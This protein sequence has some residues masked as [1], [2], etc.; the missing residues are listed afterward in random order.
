MSVTTTRSREDGGPGL[1]LGLL[2]GGATRSWREP[3]SRADEVVRLSLYADLTAKAE[4]AKLHTVFE[5]DGLTTDPADPQP[6]LEPVTLL[7]ALSARTD[8]I[9]L[10]GSVSTSFTEPYNLAR[11]IASLDHISGGRA[12]WNIVTSAWGEQNFGKPLPPHDE[13]YAVAEEFTSLVE[14]LWASWDPDAIV[15]DVD[16]N[17]FVDPAKVHSV[18]WV[19][20]HFSVRGPLD[21]PATPQGRPILAQAGSSTAGK[22]FG[23]RHADVVFTTGLIDL[24]ESQ[25][26]Y[27]DIRRRVVTAGRPADSIKILPG[28]APV[29]GSTDEEAHRIWQESLRDIDIER[30]RAA[31]AKQFGDLDL[32]DFDVDQPIPVALLPAEEQIQGRRSRYGVLR[33]LLETGQLRTLRDLIL[34]H[35]SAAGHWFPIGSA[36]RIVDQLQERWEKGAADGFNFLPFFLNYPAGLSAITEGL[37]PELQRRHLFHTD[38]EF[39]TLRGNLGLGELAGANR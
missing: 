24:A 6:G 9:G 16:R 4:A 18:D 12:G 20:D 31:L 25:E 33:R 15:C 37:V 39:E 23:A 10:I 8:R 22:D 11:Q 26:I 3:W 35:A 5:A 19:S 29:V 32:S 13:R 27:A 2:L 21:V 1:I 38:Y 30:G 17:L 36:E 7:S 34:Y 28:V 14:R